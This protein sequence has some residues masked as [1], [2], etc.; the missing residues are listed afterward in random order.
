MLNYSLP[1]IGLSLLIGFLGVN[2]KMGF[3]GYFFSSMLL[4]PI[5][6]VLLLLAS[7]PKSA[8]KNDAKHVI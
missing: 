4:S 3:W 5:M 8:T 2:R 6:G 7:D 1:Y